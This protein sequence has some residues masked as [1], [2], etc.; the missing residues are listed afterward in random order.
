VTQ[1]AVVK[2]ADRA[3][4]LLELFGEHHDGLTLSEV[5]TITGWPKSSSFGLLRTLHQRRFLDMPGSEGTYRLGPRIASLA[6]GYLGQLSIVR[7]GTEVVRAVSRRCNETVHLAVLRG[8]DV[9]Y[10]AKEEGG[11]QVR[12]VS[13]IGRTIPAH[14]TGVGKVLL[15][16]LDADEFDRLYPPGTLLPAS[17]PSTITDRERLMEELAAVRRQGFAFDAGESTAG[18]KCIA[19]PVLNIDGN[20]VAAMSVSVP[21]ARFTEDRIPHLF[22]HLT[23]GARHLSARMACPPGHLPRPVLKPGKVVPNGAD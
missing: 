13:S 18:V 4:Q 20:T 3:L 17:T 2:S 10:V 1:L 6:A 5:C 15:A 23:E 19:A 9:L 8:T 11:G 16:A 22:R 12:M 7:E 14:G 21:S